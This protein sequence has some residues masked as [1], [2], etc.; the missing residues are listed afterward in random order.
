MPPVKYVKLASGEELLTV[1]ME[2]QDGFFNFKH[3]VKISHIKDDKGEEGVRFTKW[4]PFTEDEVIPVSA[5]YIV[6]ITNLSP[7]MLKIYK[8]ILNEVSDIK[9]EFVPLDRADMLL[10]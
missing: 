3:P 7:K 1:Y 4:I 10:N 2:P 8:D 5:K 6:T 9:E